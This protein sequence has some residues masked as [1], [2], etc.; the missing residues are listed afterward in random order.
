MLPFIIAAG[1]SLIGGAIGEAFK[2][3]GRSKQEQLLQAA[4]DE[5]GRIDP[6][7]FEEL[8]TQEL[9]PSAVA[10]KTATDRRLT[11]EQYEGLDRYGEIVDAGGLDP[12]AKADLYRANTSAARTAGGNINRIQQSLDDRGMGNSGASVVLRAKAAQDANEN[13]HAGAIDAASGAWARRMQ[14]LGAKTGLAGTMRSQE[15]SEKARRAEAEDSIARYNA[16]AR[17]S[18]GR[19]RNGMK[20]QAWDNQ[21]RVAQA[22]AS[23][24]TGQAQ[25]AK[26]NADDAGNL[27]VGVGQ[28]VGGAVVDQAD[29]NW[30]SEEREKDRKAGYR[31]YYGGGY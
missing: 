9:G 12:M 31:P 2:A 8:V 22:K 3:A 26:Q 16:D 5:F 7:K 28:T 27:A 10:T 14:A 30:Q 11:D 17:T 19:Y 23:A 6:A 20:Q 1:A 18:A 24:A 25:T 21:F 4:M 29:R 15:F 13:A